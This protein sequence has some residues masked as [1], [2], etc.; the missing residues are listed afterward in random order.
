MLGD[1]RSEEMV[2]P[3]SSSSGWVSSGRGWSRREG[4]RLGHGMR[5][6]FTTNSAGSFA[7]TFRFQRIV[8]FPSSVT[9]PMVE[10]GTSYLS[11]ISSMGSVEPGDSISSI[12]SC[13]SDIII[14]VGDMSSSR[15]FTLLSS[16][17]TPVPPL[18]AISGE[19]RGE[20]AS[21]R[22]PS[23]RGSASWA[24]PPSERR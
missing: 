9:L 23:S 12:L 1:E 21:A 7:T 14:S 19:R 11:R 18:E 20:A 3:R 17:S 13:D 8:R 4:L 10:C 5:G 6:A 16:T 2:R 22:D 15:R 24:R